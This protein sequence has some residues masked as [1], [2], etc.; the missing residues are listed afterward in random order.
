MAGEITGSEDRLAKT[1]GTLGLLPGDTGFTR[2]SASELKSIRDIGVDHQ[3]FLDALFGGDATK[4]TDSRTGETKIERHTI[5]GELDNTT[6]PFEGAQYTF[7]VPLAYFGTYLNELTKDADLWGGLGKLTGLERNYNTADRLLSSL[8][9]GLLLSPNY[10]PP[11][12][13]KVTEEEPEIHPIPYKPYGS[14]SKPSPY[15]S[16]DY[17]KDGIIVTELPDYNLI[18]DLYD[19]ICRYTKTKKNTTDYN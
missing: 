18:E 19:Q 17:N 4:T 7:G 15:T 5:L 1:I 2:I 11:G 8:I 9:T 10:K 3:P 6:T 12:S 14:T 13:K 16:A